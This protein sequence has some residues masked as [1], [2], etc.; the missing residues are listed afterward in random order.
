LQ[1]GMLYHNVMDTESTSYVVQSV[2][3]LKGEVDR[4]KIGQA[5]MLL[6]SRHDVLRSAIVRQDISKPRQIVLKN[7]E[8]EYEKINLTELNEVK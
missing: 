3:N 7:K 8:V 5:L 6:A 2:Y 1:E 4:D